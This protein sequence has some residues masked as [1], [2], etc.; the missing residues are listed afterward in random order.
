MPSPSES[1][2]FGLAKPEPPKPLPAPS[3]LAAGAHGHGAAGAR[4]GRGDARRGGRDHQRGAA[5]ARDRDGAV[6][7]G[8]AGGTGV[9]DRRTLARLHLDDLFAPRLE[10]VGPFGPTE[11]R[12]AQ[13]SD[14]EHPSDQSGCHGAGEP[15]IAQSQ[16][17]GCPCSRDWCSSATCSNP[18]PRQLSASSTGCFSLD[19]TEIERFRA[20]MD[21][22]STRFRNGLEIRR[23][24]HISENQESGRIDRASSR[25]H[26]N[27]TRS[28]VRVRG[29][30]AGLRGG[31]LRR[32][33]AAR[34]GAPSRPRS[35]ATGRSPRGSP[36]ASSSAARRSTT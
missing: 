9:S 26:R 33:R 24:L 21:E 27:F 17:G 32:P 15:Q 16:P 30:P 19:A 36:T 1:L 7:R 6:A 3:L 12:S 5:R 2:R 18:L 11:E 4:A 20:E 31:R 34:R 28:R 29:H 13:G 23:K 35:R 25:H 22:R 10:R 8:G 14:A